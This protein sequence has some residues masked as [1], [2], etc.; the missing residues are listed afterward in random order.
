MKICDYCIIMGLVRVCFYFFSESSALHKCWM[1]R[2]C[3]RHSFVIFAAGFPEK[4]YHSN[5]FG[6]DF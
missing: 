1:L 3:V 6:Y 4:R 5:I 2:A